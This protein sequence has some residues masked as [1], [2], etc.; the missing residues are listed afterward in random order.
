VPACSQQIFV[1]SP[2]HEPATAFR[3]ISLSLEAFQ[4]VDEPIALTVTGNT[5]LDI[6]LMQGYLTL[7]FSCDCDTSPWNYFDLD[8]SPSIRNYLGDSTQF[9]PGERRGTDD[10]H[11]GIDFYL[12]I[13]TPLYAMAPGVV[14][15]GANDTG[16]LWV[17][18]R[19]E[20]ITVSGSV[21]VCHVG[22]I[23][24]YRV[25]N[26]ATVKRGEPIAISGSTGTA[27]PHVHM[28]LNGEGGPS[29]VYRDTLAPR[30][31][32]YWTV[33]NNPQCFP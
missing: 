22:H 33:D 6:A 14:E 4:P 1:E 19:V 13:G 3:Y 8:P 24:E 11:P 7:P 21:M 18:I 9:S 26:G 15:N 31:V 5:S 32:S 12:P 20:G 10:G 2:S 17:A 28:Q 25:A 29:D 27:W 30:S 23:S 16:A